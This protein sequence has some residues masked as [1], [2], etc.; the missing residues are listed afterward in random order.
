MGPIQESTLMGS[1]P[2][3]PQLLAFDLDHAANDAKVLLA[4][5]GALVLVRYIR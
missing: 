3:A 5:P 4:E 2:L 1:S